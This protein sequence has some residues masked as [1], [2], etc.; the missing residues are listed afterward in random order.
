MPMKYLRTWTVVGVG[1]VALA[2]VW[3][4]STRETSNQIES[5]STGQPLPS[6]D[7][8]HYPVPPRT[9]SLSPFTQTANSNTV[10]GGTSADAAV[11]DT[12]VDKL[13]GRV[14]PS[15]SE[16]Q[17]GT[18]SNHSVARVGEAPDGFGPNVEGVN[19]ASADLRSQDLRAADLNEANLANADLRRADLRE[20]NLE[21]ANLAG[22]DLREANLERAVLRGAYFQLADLS[23]AN[24]LGA[25]LRT[26][27]VG[28][29]D[30]RAAD[31]REVDLSIVSRSG[32][33][34]AT[35]FDGS[36]LRGVDA[37]G[38]DFTGSLFWQTNLEG[39][40]LRGANL[41]YAGRLEMAKLRGALYDATTKFHPEFDPNEHG[42]ILDVGTD[43]ADS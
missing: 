24:L 14:S 22:A 43:N 2:S 9:K 8:R 16:S 29:A 35:S 27:N 18:P 21:R 31:L 40:D 3:T 25:D 4:I 1:I 41:E 32:R 15:S 38:V 28:S 17:Y 36:D 30:L 23:G 20:G 34:Y 6:A 10:V 11:V 33:H 26:A 12:A 7:Q 39:A 5:A 13:D 42:M 19:L 37:R